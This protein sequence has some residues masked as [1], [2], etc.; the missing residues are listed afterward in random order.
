MEETAEDTEQGGEPL[1][2]EQAFYELKKIRFFFFFCISIFNHLSL[3]MGTLK[4]PNPSPDRKKFINKVLTGLVN[5]LEM[6]QNQILSLANNLKLQHEQRV[7]QV[8]LFQE[9]IS[10]VIPQFLF[11]STVFLGFRVSDEFWVFVGFRV[12]N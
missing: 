6:Q 8:N 5:Q 9:K 1:S 3:Q 12:S 11:T 10:Q 7:T 4:S 2:V